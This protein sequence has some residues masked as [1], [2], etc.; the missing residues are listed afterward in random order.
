MNIDLRDVKRYHRSK[1][2]SDLAGSALFV[3]YAGAWAWWAGHPILD[4]SSNRWIGMLVFA[5]CFGLGFELLT[6]GLTYY[7]DF[8]VEHRYGLSNQTRGRWL[9]QLFKGLLMGGVLGAIVLAGLYGLLW[10]GGPRWWLWLWFGWIGLTVVLAKLFPVVL[11]PVFYKSAVLEDERITTS[12]AR[13]AD[14]AALRLDGIYS[15]ELSTDTKAANA[16]LTGLG[17]TR[18]VYLSDTLLE[19]FPPEEIDVVFAH[20][21]G[22]HTRK[23]IRKQ[24]CTSALLATLLIGVVV[25]FLHPLRGPRPEQWPEAVSMLPLVAMG[26]AIVSL[27]LK[28]V[29][30]AVSR[31]FE[32]QCD[33]D[34]LRRTRDPNAYRSAMQ[35]LAGMNLADPDPHPLIEWYFYDHPAMSKRIAMADSAPSSS[36]PA[37]VVSQPQEVVGYNE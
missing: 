15:L 24:L 20:E 18:R 8:V 28:P 32:R 13:M 22:H 4:W 30:N 1:L 2:L 21:L 37:P 10:Y 9:N 6:L 36:S 29:T 14:D 16:M 19:S 23:H 3:V 25:Y 17:S 11:L 33:G 7:S 35:R 31:Q 26:I 12:L 5:G 34:A 27:V